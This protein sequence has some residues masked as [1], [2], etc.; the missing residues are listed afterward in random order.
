VIVAWVDTAVIVIVEAMVMAVRIVVVVDMA[1]VVIAT[2]MDLVA[3]MHCLWLK[4][5]AKEM[6]SSVETV[7]VI[8]Q[9]FCWRW[10]LC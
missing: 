6:K 3:V 2:G 10:W 1:V 8:D 9:G 7:V 5:L 4:R